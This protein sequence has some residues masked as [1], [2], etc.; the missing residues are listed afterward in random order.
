MELLVWVADW[1]MQ[2]CGTPFRVGSRISWTLGPADRRGLAELLGQDTAAAVDRVEDHHGGLPEHT[3]ATEATVTRI[4]AVHC[5]YEPWG[6][7]RVLHPVRGSAAF[8]PA[9]H[10]DGW[11]PNRGDLEFV[12]YLVRLA[13]SP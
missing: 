7:S 6:E 3:P 10:A 9:D 11:T 13:T 12:G 8:S 1:Q 2:C 5:R 4:T